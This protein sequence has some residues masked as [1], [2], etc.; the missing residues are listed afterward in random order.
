MTSQRAIKVTSKGWGSCD[1]HSIG[2]DKIDA[3][4]TTFVGNYG[5]IAL[6]CVIAA[7][8]AY[9]KFLRPGDDSGLIGWPCLG[10]GVLIVLIAIG[11]QKRFIEIASGTTTMQLPFSLL[12]LKDSHALVADIEST[13]VRREVELRS[14][15]V[16]AAAPSRPATPAAVPPTSSGDRLTQLNALRQQGLITEEEFAAKRQVI[17]DSM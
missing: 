1:M 12:R 2:V 9:F 8:G 10:A 16:G 14:Q 4:K 11:T 7:A 3:I 6:G 13:K 17:L 15:G 5:L